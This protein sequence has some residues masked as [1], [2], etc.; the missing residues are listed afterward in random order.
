MCDPCCS[1]TVDR[2]VFCCIF[3]LL[4]K[5]LLI[6]AMADDI[7]VAPQTIVSPELIAKTDELLSSVTQLL[8]GEIECMYFA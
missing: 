6:E 4:F 1:P 5:C 8:N 7:P 2:C 3:I